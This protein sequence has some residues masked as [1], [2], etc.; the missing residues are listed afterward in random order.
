[1]EEVFTNIQTTYMN[2]DNGYFM[3]EA[4]VS[5]ERHICAKKIVIEV[6]NGLIEDLVVIGGC[7]GNLSAITKLIRGLSI[8]EVIDKLSDIRCGFKETSC[9]DTIAYL[10]KKVFD[11]K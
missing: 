4:D 1:M 5:K 10:L 9:P 3:V 8:E 7:S 6:K 2:D 11:V